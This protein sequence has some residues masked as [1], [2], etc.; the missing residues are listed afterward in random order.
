MTS[1]DFFLALEELEK[2]KG[3]DREIFLSA[4]ENALFGSFRANALNAVSALL[5]PR[6]RSRMLCGATVCVTTSA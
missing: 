1:K 4:L 3:L 5:L 2:Q 6:A